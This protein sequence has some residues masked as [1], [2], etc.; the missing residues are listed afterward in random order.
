MYTLGPPF[1]NSFN[2]SETDNFIRLARLYSERYRVHKLQ[3]ISED[4]IRRL[5]DTPVPMRIF[6]WEGEIDTVMTPNDSIVYYKRYLRAGLMSVDPSNGHIKAY[7]GGIDYRHFMYDQVMQGRRQVGSIF[8]PFVYTLAMQEGYSPCYE[9]PNVPVQFKYVSA[10]TGNDTI[11]EP[12]YSYHEKYN[13]KM[14]TLKKG[15]AKSMNQISAWVIKRYNPQSVINLVRKMGVKSPIDPVWP[16]CVGS[17]ELPVYEVVGAF[18]TY[19]NKGIWVEPI[20]VSRIED[21]DGNIISN[22]QS[23][24]EEAISEFAAY[25]MLNLMEGVTSGDGTGIRLIW[26]FPCGPYLC[27]NAMLTVLFSFRRKNMNLL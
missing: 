7:V 2:K 19:A 4:S 23:K 26:L 24:E 18:T 12:K 20:L 11:Y 1:D 15:L 14:V 25:K 5:F 8:K 13:G 16:I 3:R 10:T 22:F 9:V 27:K 21:K 6:S 17:A